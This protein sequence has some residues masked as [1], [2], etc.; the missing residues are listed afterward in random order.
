MHTCYV[1]EGQLWFDVTRITKRTAIKRKLAR[2]WSRGTEAQ[3]FLQE[4]A[5]ISAVEK[6]AE[7][8]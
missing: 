3:A 7:Y 1:I 6:Q 8:H 2:I 4:R 5:G